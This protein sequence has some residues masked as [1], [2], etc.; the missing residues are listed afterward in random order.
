MVFGVKLRS[1]QRS[2]ALPH[3][4]QSPTMKRSLRTFRCKDSSRK[5]PRPAAKVFF[6]CGLFMPT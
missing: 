1:Q 2:A 6:A 4:L 5:F 3:R